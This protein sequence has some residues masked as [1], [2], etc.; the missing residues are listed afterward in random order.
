M[1][2]HAD[3]AEPARTATLTAATEPVPPT[4]P[5]RAR[6]LRTLPDAAAVGLLA[7]LVVAINDVG[8][9]LRTPYWLDEAWVALS[10]RLPLSDPVLVTASTPLGWTLLLRLVPDPEYLR[11]VPF[12]FI[13]G[14]VLGG[15]ALGRTLAWK[16]RFDG[17]LVGL[18]A[19]AATLL[20]PAQQA[21]HDLKQY[22][23]D[24]AVAL[25]LL[26]LVARA[27]ARWSRARLAT[28]LATTA[29]GMLISHTTAVVAPCAIAG[30][31]VVSVARRQWRRLAEVTVAG[32]L[33]G[34]AVL[35]IYLGVTVRGRTDSL[36][37]YWAGYFPSLGDLPG[38]LNRRLNELEPYLGAPW[39]LVLALAALGVLVIAWTGRPA[40]ALAAAGVPAALVVLGLAGAYP[41]LDLRTS[42]FLL[43][44]LA[45]LS[46]IGVAGVL[47]LAAAASARMA[48]GTATV[49]RT[50]AAIL[51]V[52]ALAGYAY[53]NREWLRTDDPGTEDLRTATRYVQERWRP[54]DVVVVS[55]LGSLG[56]AFYWTRDDPGLE[57]TTDLAIGW[58]P[59]YP[60]QSGIVITKIRTAASI[61]AALAEAERRH[62][63]AGG[64][65]RVWLV[66]SHIAGGEQRAWT[67][68]LAPYRVEPT[69]IA[70]DVVV[71]LHPRP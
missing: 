8:A 71:L 58:R 33:T 32:A 4:V 28:I 6:W 51:V 18:A 54:G 46:G 11:L 34:A 67:A 47:I 40:T 24:A 42:H 19:G 7:V 10:V 31:V 23:A 62:A 41:L 48:P 3:P 22:T 68:A 35:G 9:I 61:R 56:F 5:A 59:A 55:A 53:P 66:R 26:L 27:E 39:P 30:L 70:H 64:I 69:P 21:R 29:A 43:I 13:V 57:R 50:A 2:H 37:D 15:Y 36:Q 38:Y 44:L 65:G 25:L 63:D 52:V 45:A 20:P 16:S 49:A 60:P 14:G 17:V 1:D 12:A